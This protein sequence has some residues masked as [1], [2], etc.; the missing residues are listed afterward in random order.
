MQKPAFDPGLTRQFGAPLRRAI[1]KDGSFNVHRTGVSWRAFHPWL[2]VVNMSWPGFSA[3]VMLTFL[4]INTAFALAYFAMGP[5]H[6]AKAAGFSTISSSAAI[7]SRQSDMA[8]YH[9]TASAPTSSP[10]SKPCSAYSVSR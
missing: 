10:R 9:P 1:N 7:L 6:P 2:H 8:R 4:G 5:T 3:L